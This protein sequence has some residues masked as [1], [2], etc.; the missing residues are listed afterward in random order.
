MSVRL[1]DDEAVRVRPA[2][3]VCEGVRVIDVVSDWLLV[4]VEDPVSVTDGVG[5]LEPVRVCVAECEAVC[6]KEGIKMA[7]VSAVLVPN[8]TH[9]KQTSL[10]RL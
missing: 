4:R 2:V 8:C 1:C 9:T 6:V 7:P 3:T 5:V 10:R